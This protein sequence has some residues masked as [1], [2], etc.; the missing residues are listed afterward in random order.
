MNVKLITFAGNLAAVF[1][2]QSFWQ[3]GVATKPKQGVLGFLA[4]G[5]VWF[6]VPFV[7]GT[8]MGLAY[9]ALGE[10]RGSPLLDDDQV[11]QGLFVSYH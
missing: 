10:L 4:G 2:E 9:V 3:C 8:T 1:V 11:T 6:S 7:F 5:L